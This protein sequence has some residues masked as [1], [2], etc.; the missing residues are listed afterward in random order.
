MAV[1]SEVKTKKFFKILND[2]LKFEDGDKITSAKINRLFDNPSVE[3]FLTEFVQT[4]TQD[5]VVTDGEIARYDQIVSQGKNKSGV[6]VQRALDRNRRQ[7]EEYESQKSKVLKAIEVMK[8]KKEILEYEIAQMEKLKRRQEKRNE[9]LKVIANESNERLRDEKN[10]LQACR[11]QLSQTLVNFDATFQSLCKLFEG[12]DDD[13]AHLLSQVSLQDLLQAEEAYNVQLTSFV[14]KQFHGAYGSIS[15]DL[16]G[17]DG[18]HRLLSISDEHLLHGES[19]EVRKEMADDIR[20]AEFGYPAREKRLISSKARSAAAESSLAFIQHRHREVQES[21]HAPSS[22]DLRSSLNGTL[23]KSAQLKEQVRQL[24]QSKLPELI[25]RG[26]PLQTTHLLTG[27]YRRKLIRQEYFMEKQNIVIK[28]LLQQQ[29]RLDLLWMLVSLEEA[30]HKRTA[31]QVPEVLHEL[32]DMLTRS[33]EET[34]RFLS[35]KP[36]EDPAQPRSVIDER[37]E[38]AVDLHNLLVDERA[39]SS[40]LFRHFDGLR[41]SAEE[42]RKRV[43]VVQKNTVTDLN[44]DATGISDLARSVASCENILRPPIAASLNGSGDSDEVI[45]TP[46]PITKMASHLQE[47]FTNLSCLIQKNTSSI[48]KKRCHLEHQESAA[49][50]RSLW[51]DFFL[52]PDTLKSRVGCPE[53]ADS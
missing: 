45:L 38:V 14:K 8:R 27:D 36:A 25:E 11:A 6:E 7:N 12:S 24:S 20:R 37:D 50:A 53:H 41:S 47:Q 49:A 33:E 1:S 26:T 39:K 34:E 28:L 13:G 35:C 40:S 16:N 48:E 32:K 18:A 52:R 29:A 22:E 43:D 9:D 2:D 3:A 23:G 42:L 44:S 46:E 15:Q 17:N 10:N 30:S 19:E 51:V 21:R 31:A 5:N 4:V